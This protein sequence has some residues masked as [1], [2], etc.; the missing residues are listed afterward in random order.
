MKG[1]E[2]NIQ[3]VSNEVGSILPDGVRGMVLG[4]RAK[5]ARAIEGAS[6]PAQKAELESALGQLSDDA[7]LDH[8][9]VLSVDMEDFR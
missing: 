7:V 3:S 5:L 4:M 6:S 9:H 2:G 8:L 1:K